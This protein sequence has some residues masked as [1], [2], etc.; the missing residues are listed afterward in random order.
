[1]LIS[2]NNLMTRALMVVESFTLLSAELSAAG[3]WFLQVKF[4]AV[5]K[6]EM[7]FQWSE[8]ISLLKW[9]KSV[10]ESSKQVIKSAINSKRVLVSSKLCSLQL[11]LVFIYFLFTA[12]FL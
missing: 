4:L 6:S 7:P 11:Q 10:P 1:M 9:Y 12:C 3:L 5:E 2:F 8:S